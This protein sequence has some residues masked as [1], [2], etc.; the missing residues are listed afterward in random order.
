MSKIN[1]LIQNNSRKDKDCYLCS[2]MHY[3][4][5]LDNLRPWA[6]NEHVANKKAAALFHPCA[7]V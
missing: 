5:I 7:G 2:I 4:E 3:T 6:V 1:H